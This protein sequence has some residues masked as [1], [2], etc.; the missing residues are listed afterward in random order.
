MARDY[1]AVVA[2]YQDRL[3]IHLR[4]HRLVTAY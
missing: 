3:N 2:K 4:Y 1:Q